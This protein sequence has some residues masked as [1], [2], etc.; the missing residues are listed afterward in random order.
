MSAIALTLGVL[1][2]QGRHVDSFGRVRQMTESLAGQTVEGALRALMARL[3]CEGIESAELAARVPCGG[4]R[5]LDVTGMIA[6][7]GRSLTSDESMRLE[8]FVHRRL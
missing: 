7:A 3:K 2:L 6:A 4:A 1:L 5:G 8:D